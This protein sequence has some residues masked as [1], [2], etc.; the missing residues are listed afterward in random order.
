M[1]HPKDVSLSDTGNTPKLT[2]C[3][4]PS[5]KKVIVNRDAKFSEEESLDWNENER[6]GKS[7]L[8]DLDEETYAPSIESEEVATPPSSPVSSPSNSSSLSSS[9]P[10]TPPLKT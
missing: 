8:V 6:K 7:I 3:T 10:T 5:P 2:S 1:K 9:S 4:I